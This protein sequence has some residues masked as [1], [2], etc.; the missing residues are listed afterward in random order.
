MPSSDEHINEFLSYLHQSIARIE[1]LCDSAHD[2][3]CRSFK[4][5]LLF[6]FIDNLSTLAYPAS[7]LDPARFRRLVTEHGNWD[8]GHLISIPHLCRWIEVFPTGLSSEGAEL[9]RNRINEWSDGSFIPISHDLQ[10]RQIEPYIN[11]ANTKAAQGILRLTHAS[12]LWNQRHSLIHRF[13]P[14]GLGIEF[15]DDKN[16]Y[17]I[18]ISSL[19]SIFDQPE[20]GRAW[21]LIYPTDFL[22]HLARQCLAGVSEVLRSRPIDLR[23]HYRAGLYMWDELNQ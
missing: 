4:K 7:S 3:Q 16:P 12:L 23:S 1:N 14:S 19:S 8:D 13:L 9:A 20:E 10:Y 5:T 11:P 22:F 17:Y 18:G 15:P 21:Q 2:S 6:S